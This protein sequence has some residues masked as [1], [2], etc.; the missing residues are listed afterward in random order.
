MRRHLPTPVQAPRRADRGTQRIG[1]LA[2]GDGVRRRRGLLPTSIRASGDRHT[3]L[4]EHAADRL[5]PELS[6]THL[7]DERTDQRWRG[8]SSPR[9]ENRSCHEDFV[10]LLEVSVLA[11]Q[12]LNALLLGCGHPRALL[13]VDL[14]LQYPLAQGLRTDPTF[15]PI[16]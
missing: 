16:A 4:G 10:N 11:L 1:H 6:C 14:S 9:E 7:F 15:G 5:D 12:L 3:L 13:S 2:I 8:S